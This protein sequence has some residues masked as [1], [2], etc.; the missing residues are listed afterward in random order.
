MLFFSAMKIMLGK[1][2]RQWIV[3]DAKD[4]GYTALHLAAFNNH[5]EVAELLVRGGARPDLQNAN[6]QTALHLAVERQHTQIVRLLIAHGANLNICDKDGDTPLH[7][8]LRHHT[9]QQLRRLQDARDASLLSGIA[10]AHDKKSSASIACFL[11]AHGADLTV[12]NKKGQ[13]PLDLCPDPNLR[14]TLTTCRKEGTG[15]PIDGTPDSEAPPLAGPSCTPA[16]VEA[17]AE[18]PPSDPTADECLVCSDAKRDTLF[19]P[20][21]HICCCNVC[22]AR[23]KKC[24]VCRAGVSARQRVGECVVCSEAPATVVFRPCG[25]VCACA[26]CA[27]LMRKCVE[28]RTPLQPAQPPAQPS[29]QPPAPAAPSLPTPPAESSCAPLSE[30]LKGCCPAAGEGGGNLALL[31]AN[32]GQPAPAPAAPH[33]LNNGARCAA[34]ADVQ[35]LQQ[36]L[37]DIKE[38]TMCPICLDRLKN[39]IFLCGHGMCQMCGDRITVCPICR[40]TVEK[41]ILLY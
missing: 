7:E 17:P 9:L 21:G 32:K 33:L 14:K 38:Q 2:P 3:D 19:R 22:A 8:A 15:L 10:H 6:L 36:Q 16:A 1:L 37:Q 28:C 5:A 34:P 12:K 11:A 18:A 23:V 41:R 31:Q 20:C 35:K 4:D 13:T 24:L 30:T 25:D 39:M 29:A 40:K 27:P 26:A